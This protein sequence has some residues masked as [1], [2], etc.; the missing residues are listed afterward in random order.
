MVSSLRRWVA[1]AAAVLAALGL[2][3][4][5]ASSA[6]A[7]PPRFGGA[8]VLP[9][10][11]A[12][13]QPWYYQPNPIQTYYANQYAYNIAT[14]GRAYSYV[15]PYALGYNPYP[16]YVNYGP[17]YAPRYYNPYAYY[18]PYGVYGYYGMY[19]PYALYG[20]YYGY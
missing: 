14:I 6:K 2:F 3:L 7:L 1:P 10:S 11:T 17:V 18:N 12:F 4:A 8:R 20:Y 9:N 16:A 5:T 19:N 13:V 15:P